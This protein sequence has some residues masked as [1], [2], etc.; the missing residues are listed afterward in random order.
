MT[1]SKKSHVIVVLVEG[2]TDKMALE[3]SFNK[4]STDSIHKFICTRGDTTSDKTIYNKTSDEIIKE[5]IRNYINSHSSFEYKDIKQIIQIIDTDGLFCDSST[6]VFEKS[7]EHPIYGRSI[8]NVKNVET[9]IKTRNMKLERVL[10]LIKK[11]YVICDKRDYKSFKEK[12]SI[13]YSVYYHSCNLDDVICN[14]QNLPN[15]AE[16]TKNATQF[17]LKYSENVQGFL[18]FFESMNKSGELNFV[19]SWNYL[20]ENNISLSRC[21]N[22]Y[23]YLSLMKSNNHN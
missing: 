4:L 10:E 22:L 15:G 23:L 6:V 11:R 18:D 19:A 3:S 16:K 17:K 7:A 21:S 14:N 1:T 5:Y 13:P 20:K 12:H 2:P 8:T 9:F